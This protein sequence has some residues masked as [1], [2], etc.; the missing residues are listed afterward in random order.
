[1]KKVT[2]KNNF[3]G[4]Q[5]NVIPKETKSGWLVL[6]HSQMKAAERKLCGMDGCTCPTFGGKLEHVPARTGFKEDDIYFLLDANACT[7]HITDL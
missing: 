4:T 7:V 6:T 2:L 1:M 5:C 3:H